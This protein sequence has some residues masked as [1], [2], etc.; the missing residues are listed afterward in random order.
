MAS[1]QLVLGTQEVENALVRRRIAEHYICT[2]ALAL[3]TREVMCM[4]VREGATYA[5]CTY[6]AQYERGHVRA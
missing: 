1:L 5:S 3:T 6:L 2:L 4:C